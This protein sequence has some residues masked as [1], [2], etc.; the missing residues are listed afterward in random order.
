MHDTIV[1]GATMFLTETLPGLGQNQSSPTWYR[2]HGCFCY[3]ELLA[4]WSH[5]H[6]W[7]LAKGL[8]CE[9]PLSTLSTIAASPVLGTS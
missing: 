3:S 1:R 9:W 8:A 7:N 4:W 6:A 5:P 2:I